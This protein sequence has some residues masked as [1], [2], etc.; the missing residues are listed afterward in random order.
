METL[1]LSAAVVYK[2]NMQQQDHTQQKSGRQSNLKTG[3]E[4][5]NG[6]RSKEQLNRLEESALGTGEA[7]LPGDNADTIEAERIAG[8]PSGDNLNKGAERLVGSTNLSLDDLKK[9]RL[10]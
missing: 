7:Q 4:I 2:K 10:R 3:S 5:I 8:T 1:A 9:R 6:A